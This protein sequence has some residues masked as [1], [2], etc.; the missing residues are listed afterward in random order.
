MQLSRK[1]K[2]LKATFKQNNT[3]CRETT[4]I[5]MSRF[6]MIAIIGI[7][8][9]LAHIV[10]FALKTP[11][12]DT[13]LMWRNGIIY[14]HSALLVLFIIL[15]IF[16][17]YIK[18][19]TLVFKPMYVFI[20]YGIIAFILL[21]G[22]AITAIDQLVVTNITPYFVATVVA[23][24]VF[25]MRP[26][27]SMIL[28]G[29]F[30][31]VFV[32]I[33]SIVIDDNVIALTNQVNGLTVTGLS[34]LLSVLL[35]QSNAKNVLQI[36][37]IQSQQD[38][39]LESNAKLDYLA[40]HDVAT[41]L[42]NRPS[43]VS[44]VEQSLQG[45]DATAALMMIDLDN[46]KRIN[47]DYGHPVG[48]QLLVQ[49]SRILKPFFKAQSIVSRWG[50]EEFLVFIPEIDDNE[51]Y[52]MAEALRQRI[53]NHTFTIDNL[54]LD[55]TISIGV[56]LFKDDFQSAYELTDKALYQAKELGRNRVEITDNKKG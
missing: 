27:M 37:V 10:I 43:F 52:A 40:T 49:F 20:Q 30:Y 15:G 51:V 53:S 8:I 38:A 50:G 3:I 34:L 6:F 19:K 11:I 48:D 45:N 47:D 42:L 39:L 9:S 26:M 12:N 24:L 23:A 44:R 13:E 46:F 31:T 29:I 55:I 28:Y 32:I 36:R 22:I 18:R 54:K 14:A 35:W 2:T 4:L 56:T 5:N 41:D 33:I 16:G 17:Y 21:M 7:P 25:F 1:I